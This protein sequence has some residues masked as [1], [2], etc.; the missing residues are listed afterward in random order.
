MNQALLISQI[1]L[2]LLAGLAAATLVVAARRVGALLAR[3]PPGGALMIDQ[4]PAVGTAAPRFEVSDLAGQ[5]VV[6]GATPDGLCTLLL[7][8][9]STCPV[10]RKLLPLVGSL[11]SAEADWLRIVLVGD[12]EPEAEAARMRRYALRSVPFVLSEAVGR[13]FRIGRLP[14]AVLMDQDGFVRAKGL[15]NSR[16]HLES[17]FEAKER[18]VASL[19]EFLRRRGADS[20]G[21]EPAA[22]PATPPA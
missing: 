19:Q 16:Q 2:W 1:V 8:V 21:A 9:S 3:L 4:G 14:Y 13:G 18:G 7:F 17:L 12:G 5:P 22:A 20:A 11:A 15:V 6:I 10:C